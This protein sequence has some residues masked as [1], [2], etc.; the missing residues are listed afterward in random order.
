MDTNQFSRNR[1]KASKPSTFSSIA[2]KALAAYGAYWF[3]SWAW[4]EFG[5]NPTIKKDSEETHEKSCLDPLDVMQKSSGDCR[6]NRHQLSMSIVRRRQQRIA[7][8][9]KE[10]I[11]TMD[12]LLVTLKNTI[13]SQTDFSKQ[14][15][16]LKQMRNTDSLPLS[17]QTGYE[18][19]LKRDLWDE[20]KIKSVTR[21]VVTVY[22]H[23]LLVLL[24]IVQIH[25]LGGTLFREQLNQEP[26]DR[27]PQS[28]L[29][30]E[31][32]LM[33][34]LLQSEEEQS[35]YHKIMVQTYETF[36]SRVVSAL[37]IDIQK[38]VG[39]EL[40]KWNVIDEREQKVCNITLHD[41]EDGIN[42][43]RKNLDRIQLG[44]YLCEILSPG[45]N[46]S[47]ANVHLAF[48]ESLDVLESPVFENVNEETIN[49]T[50]DVVGMKG[51]A[52]LFHGS[53]QPL[54]NVITKLKNICNIFYTSPNESNE[55]RWVD[56]PMNS[57]PNTFLYYFDRMDS[58]KELAD[59]SF[60]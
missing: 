39:S 9:R 6:K 43:I 28:Q 48:E 18:R 23:S 37:V 38:V 35:S 3:L 5:T 7:F 52:P 11:N 26:K 17:K 32:S 22:A 1:K 21:L 41:F 12:S 46:L 40:S 47:D 25:V 14:I 51:Y 31:Q 44:Q 58:V 4:R 8:C 36:F 24:L 54:V 53:D 10:T 27:V 57:Y 56:R 59:I 16:A 50:F 45:E 13:E 2:T 34:E 19:T 29:G 49:M 33:E 42:R 60:G 20:I 30:Q 55:E 15:T